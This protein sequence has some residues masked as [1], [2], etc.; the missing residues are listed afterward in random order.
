MSSELIDEP[1][2]PEDKPPAPLRRWLIWSFII[3]TIIMLVVVGGLYARL[4]A[5]IRHIEITDADLGKPRPAKMPSGALNILVIGSDQPDTNNGDLA[6]GRADTIM[7]VHLSSERNDATVMSFP[8]DLMVQLPACRSRKGLPGQRRHRGMINAS[9]S[10]GGVGCTW[11]TIETLTGIRIDHFVKVDFNGFKAMVDA[12]GGVELC[13]SAPVHDTYVPLDL[14]AG[15]QTLHGEQALGYVRARHG[16]GDGTDIGRIQRQQ[17][18]V[19]AMAKKVKR[20]G[21]LVEPVRLF[22]LLN[23]A[24]KS[25]ITDP[26]LTPGVM[27]SLAFTAL[28]LSSDKVYFVITPWRYSAAYPGRVEWLEGSA[29]KLFRVIAADQPLDRPG[30]KETEL[31]ASQ[32]AETQSEPSASPI[33]SVITLPVPD[34]ATLSPATLSSAVPCEVN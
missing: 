9:F 14:S 20:G 11:K 30:L 8:R 7:L 19:A 26:G 24:T 2:A 22:G 31:V 21:I 28:G 32:G 13:I 5:N 6:G 1:P 16:I 4:T 3:V 23:A 33:D 10:F 29:K 15:L 18:F 12:V 25:I 27:T 17:D 34:S